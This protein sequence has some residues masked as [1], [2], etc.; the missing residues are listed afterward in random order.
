MSI[1]VVTGR[2]CLCSSHKRLNKM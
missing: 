2:Q 1:V